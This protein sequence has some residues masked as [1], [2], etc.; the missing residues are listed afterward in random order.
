MKKLLTKVLFVFLGFVLIVGTVNGYDIY[1]EGGD[2]I[3]EVNDWQLDLS[4][5]YSENYVWQVHDWDGNVIWEINED[6]EFESRADVSW[7][8]DENETEDEQ[9]N[10]NSEWWTSTIDWDDS[11]DEWDDL[12]WTLSSSINEDDDGYWNSMWQRG[13]YTHSGLT[14]TLVLVGT[15]ILRPIA[16]GIGIL[17]AM[18]WA[19]QMLFADNDEGRQTWINYILWWVVW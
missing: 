8:E 14:E 6:R 2:K 18:I 4:E 9:E 17:L 13:N 10:W 11:L 1:N 15:N 5:N 7:N 19:Y 12:L 3:W 16:I